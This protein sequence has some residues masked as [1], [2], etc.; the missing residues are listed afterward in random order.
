MSRF[1]WELPRLHELK[2][3][4][5]NPEAPDAYFQNFEENL[6]DSHI[7]E[8]Y[9][10]W[11]WAL[12]V[13]DA[14][15]WKQLKTEIVPRL[16]Q[17]TKGRGWQPLFDTLGEARGYAYLKAIGCTVVRFIPRSTGP[18]P[19]LEGTIASDR[20]LCEVKTINAS[21]AEIEARTNLPR[22]RSLPIDLPTQ[23]FI[24]LSTKIEEAK[25]Q[26]LCHDPHTEAKH[27]VYLNINFDDLFAECKERYFRQ[28]DEHLSD[29]PISGV[30]LIICNDY[31]LFYKPLQ[32][33]HAEV[34]NVGSHQDG[35]AAAT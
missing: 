14:E 20:L 27:L 30:R 33:R 34:D 29:K 22:V 13:L 4:I 19:D 3:C 8:V 26:L 32:M 35:S 28:I 5:P 10:R 23:F 16:T 12:Q 11:E 15:A 25:S 7:R 17:R 6:A 9:L 1:Q 24:K 31:T 21:A 18:T 2:D